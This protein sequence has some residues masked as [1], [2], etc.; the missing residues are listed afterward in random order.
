MSKRPIQAGR[1]LTKAHRHSTAPSQAER[2]EV[3]LTSELVY[4]DGKLDASGSGLSTGDLLGG[5]AGFLEATFSDVEPSGIAQASSG[6]PYA[7]RRP[8][9][10]ISLWRLRALPLD[11]VNGQNTIKCH[12]VPDGQDAENVWDLLS[13]RILTRWPSPNSWLPSGSGVREENITGY[14]HRS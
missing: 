1:P 11:T 5:I 7:T 2:L 10:T 8:H 4:F 13:P 12:P 3:S 9:D 6:Y 14:D